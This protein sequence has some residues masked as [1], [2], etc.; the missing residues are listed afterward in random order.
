MH[1][2]EIP[3]NILAALKLLEASD[4]DPLLLIDESMRVVWMSA[5]ME[6]ITGMK[7]EDLIGTNL[8]ALSACADARWAA[9]VYTEVQSGRE[10]FSVTPGAEAC[11]SLS[12]KRV[13]IAP[14]R[15]YW[16]IRVLKELHEK[17][18]ETDDTG[19]R[20]Q[21]PGIRAENTDRRQ[22]D[23]YLRILEAAL[24]AAT[25]GIVIT[26]LAGRI[27]YVNRALLNMGGYSEPGKL[28]G[29]DG[30][31][32]WSDDER[33]AAAV[34]GLHEKGEWLGELQ[35]RTRDGEPMDVQVAVHR[36]TDDSGN[37]I[38][39]LSCCTD[40]TGR[41]RMEEALSESERRYRTLAEASPDVISLTH[42][43]GTLLYLNRRGAE[44][45]GKKPEEI[46]G[47]NIRELFPPDACRE[48]LQIIDAVV[49]SGRPQNQEITYPRDGK[50]HYYDSRSI[51]LFAPDGTVDQV[52]SIARDLTER[53]KS[54]EQLRF[55]AQVLSQIDDAV[56]AIDA[57][58]R[59]AYF[60]TAA[61]RLYGI[62]AAEALGRHNR[63]I[64]TCEWLSPED[65]KT[66]WE[67]LNQ[68]GSWRGVAIHR[69]RDGEAIYVD[70][71]VS[72]LRDE[73][74]EITGRLGVIRDITRQ[75]QAEKE[76][77]IKDLAIASAQNAI[78]LTDIAGRVTYMNQATL[79]LWGYG[80]EDEM[81]GS[82]A[83]RF[84]T[85]ADRYRRVAEIIRER[86]GWMGELEARRKD[87]STFPVQISVT[88]VTDTAGRPLCIMG[89]GIDISEQKQA[90]EALLRS[91]REKSLI[92]DS[93]GEFFV[94]IDADF[95]IRWAN[96]AATES[97][98]LRAEDLI[99]S[100]CYEIWHS[101]SEPCAFCPLR[102]A[103]AT[104]KPQG[105]EIS[106]PDGRTWR[107]RGQPVIDAAGK[108]NGVIVFGTDITE[109]KRMEDALYAA[110]SYTRGLI[111][112]SLDPLVTISPDGRITDVNSATEAATGYP[113]EVLIGTDFS[114]YFTDPELA[115]QG[116]R[117]AFEVG[118]VRDYALELRHRSGRTTPVLYNASVYRNNEGEVA[119][120]FAAARDITG[121]KEAEAIMQS[122][123]ARQAA[124]ARLSGIALSGSD[125]QYLLDEA[126]GT[127]ADL[128]EVRYCKVLRLLPETGEFL[129]QAGTGWEDGLVGSALVEAG[130]SQAGYTLRSNEPVIVEDF[131]TET[132][133]T[134]PEILQRHR[135][136]SGISVVL[137]G[138]G[139][140]YGILGVHTGEAQH[141][142]E[143]DV[144][145]IQAVANILSQGIERRQAEEDLEMRNRHLSALNRIIGATTASTDPEEMLRTVLG[146]TL[147][148]LGFKGGAVYRI[149]ADNGSARLVHACNLPEGFPPITHT[150]DI[151]REPYSTV[152]VR[153]IPLFF[154]E[155]T[156]RYPGDPERS[157]YSAASIPLVA[158][159][160]VLGAINVIGRAGKP[161][162][163]DE[164][165]ILTRIGREIGTAVERLLLSRQLEEA[166]REA[167]L[168]LDIL[169]HDIRNA[170]NVATLYTDLLSDMLDGKPAEYVAKLRST[171][172]KSI[173]ILANV[174]TIRKIHQ[175][176]APLAPMSLERIIASEKEHF[177]EASITVDCPGSCMALADELLSE[178]FTNLIG[179]A[180]KF[181]GQDVAVTITVDEREDEMIVTVAD[182]GPGVPDEVK[183]EVFR[184][185]ERGKQ[186]GR[187]EGLGLFIVRMLIERYGGRIWIEDRVCGRPEEGAAF[188]FTLR[189]AS[190]P[191]ADGR[192]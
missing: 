102:E 47:K 145:L 93:T 104:G 110:I 160:G 130:D 165:F 151:H 41:R 182:T 133:F 89:S 71:T 183:E 192:E 186:K 101:R 37:P 46:I 108:L 87:G 134:R 79:D 5:A 91:E 34:R 100:R 74:G 127:L 6:L 146:T 27:V 73:H 174:S 154:D 40:I 20:L 52:L 112:A 180:V 122:R 178:V 12:G 116:Y 25:I 138:K 147:E 30:L 28:I 115:R 69:K 32:Y 43:D 64:V 80:A 119:G 132:R 16:I 181:G 29:T 139:A 72:T 33:K 155:E 167:N 175:K 3:D 120:V 68:T 128:L 148:L 55:Q 8:A 99:G 22:T 85:D 4:S 53:K 26:D 65:E 24:G 10:A 38:C 78:T 169:T 49:T 82:P 172:R 51:P 176:T 35:G 191:E 9:A 88:L 1:R 150:E 77:R 123:E 190:P 137:Q 7:R 45:L 57:D 121:H 11:Y 158:H 106:T 63:K 153:G 21:I 59:I 92:L 83:S 2:F 135:V 84:W 114:D 129:L 143:A 140:P 185:F 76:L 157:R 14:G 39:S 44:G 179:N 156:F 184:R 67:S 15:P 61:E 62:P 188:R 189:R 118:E 107:I 124:I 144:Y 19:R 162:T 187:G 66:A 98:G 117:Q 111:E 96:R 164:Q 18:T 166:H 13:E 142:T 48:R 17:G 90:E 131:R 113:R 95:S 36:I 159:T 42:R 75:R 125:L 149:D 56:M 109:Q 54:E 173:D 171:I 163:D 23:E 170:E 50:M 31:Q 161:F 103:F 141:F 126:V 70:T 58:G 152:L 94:Y 81:I 136:L 168:Y 60:N 177:P 105:G 86:G 97:T